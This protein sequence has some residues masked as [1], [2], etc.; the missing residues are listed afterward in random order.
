VSTSD[1][2]PSA[3]S[4]A[5][6]P[7]ESCFAGRRQVRAGLGYALEATV[8]GLMRR[9]RARRVLAFGGVSVVPYRQAEQRLTPPDPYLAAWRVRKR[10]GWI[11]I[12]SVPA[13]VVAFASL[14]SLGLVG[15]LLAA[16]L[17]LSGWLL[18]LSWA[19]FRCP[20]CGRTFG[21]HN[22]NRHCE[23]CGIERGTPVPR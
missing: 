7:Q 18:I 2:E 8:L 5:V 13:L 21:A 19:V 6:A 9:A 11:A 14:Q 23:S 22:L 10:R 20:A 12:A 16:P 15:L 3:G 1:L 17:A 4:I